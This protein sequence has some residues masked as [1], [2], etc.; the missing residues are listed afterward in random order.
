MNNRHL[1][2]NIC[3]A[4]S[5]GALKSVAEMIPHQGR[6]LGVTLRLANS[7]HK[8]AHKLRSINQTELGIITTSIQISAE[9]VDSF[10]GENYNHIMLNLVS[11]CM[12]ELKP[13]LSPNDFLTLK[14]LFECFHQSDCYNDIRLGDRVFTR[15]MSA[16]EIE[17]QMQGGS[18]EVPTST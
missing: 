8:N 10:V 13:I 2:E 9:I 4:V 15:M 18:N 16:L 1:V 3:L 12:E 11:F 14:K 5:V 17:I 7:I 6:Q